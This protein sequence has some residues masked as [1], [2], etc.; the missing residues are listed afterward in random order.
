MQSSDFWLKS[1]IQHKSIADNLSMQSGVWGVFVFHFKFLALLYALKTCQPYFQRDF[2][3]YYIRSTLTVSTVCT[4]LIATLSSIY[5]YGKCF[6]L[7]LNPAI[8]TPYCNSLL[9]PGEFFSSSNFGPCIFCFRNCHIFISIV[10][11]FS[12]LIS[13]FLCGHYLWSHFVCFSADLFAVQVMCKSDKLEEF[14]NVS[15]AKERKQRLI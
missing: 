2:G 12:S 3:Y 15:L 13:F 9:K 14:Q 11:M 6:T 1:S 7:V 4:H 10:S 8:W 5:R